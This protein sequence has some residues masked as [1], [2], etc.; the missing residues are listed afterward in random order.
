MSSDWIHDPRLSQIDKKKL[1]LLEQFAEQGSGK[2]AADTL[3][4]L[5]QVLNSSKLN[6]LQ[7]TESEIAL[8]LH[9]LKSGKTPAEL[10]RLEKILSLIKTIK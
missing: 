4:F 10:K 6:E 1:S 9:V 3:T 5:M 8:I 7:F 2:N